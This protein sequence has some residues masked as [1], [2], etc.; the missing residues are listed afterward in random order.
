[1]RTRRRRAHTA[2]GLR[3][4]A[5]R[6]GP[7]HGTPSTG[8]YH[9]RVPHGVVTGIIFSL[10]PTVVVGLVFWFV[11]RAIIRAD[12]TERATY[13][14]LEREER[15]RFTAERAA[16]GPGAGTAGPRDVQAPSRPAAVPASPQSAE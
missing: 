9:G 3:S 1:M 15:A 16:G 14:K 13:A 12:R 6:S 10:T 11:M 5:V 2:D 8:T 4:L 7:P